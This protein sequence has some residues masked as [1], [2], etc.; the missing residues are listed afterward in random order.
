M[1][2]QKPASAYLY[3]C[4]TQIPTLSS[5]IGRKNIEQKFKIKFN[6]IH[7]HFR[8][9]PGAMMRTLESFAA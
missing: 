4:S 8:I 5:A 6:K 3:S 2:W 9:P 1:I 7:T